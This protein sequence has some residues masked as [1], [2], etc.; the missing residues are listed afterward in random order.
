MCQLRLYALACLMLLAPEARSHFSIDKTRLYFDHKARHQ[1]LVLRNTSNQVLKFSIRITHADMQQ[2]G[3]FVSKAFDE[4][5]HRSIKPLLRFSPRTGN[6]RAGE[7]QVIRFTLRK[8]ANLNLG[9][10]R[11]QLKISATPRNQA[12]IVA[13]LAYNL[14]LIYRHGKT[15]ATTYIDKVKVV[16]DQG[17]YFLTF[18]QYREGNRSLFGDFSLYT[19]SGKL[20]SQVRNMSHY[21]PLQQRL[22]RLPLSAAPN[23]SWTLTYKEQAEF[24]GNLSF[25]HAFVHSQ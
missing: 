5:K 8:K 9:E 24:G 22:V 15:H 23:G 25:E 4:V 6:L 18:T 12:N 3:R 19:S 13:S 2:N 10:Y 11:S 17:R 1:A 7:D 20:L 21:P 14:P 16:Q